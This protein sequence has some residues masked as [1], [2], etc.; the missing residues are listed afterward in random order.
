[1]T[2]RRV[3][4]HYR[5][6]TRKHVQHIY[7]GI[8]GF[9]NDIEDSKYATC[10]GEITLGGMERLTSIFQKLQPILSYPVERRVFYDLGSGV[11][12]NVIMIAS[13]I[14]AIKSKGIELVKERHEKAMKAY[15]TLNKKVQSRVEL[16][17]GSFFDHSIHN[18]AW[19]FISNLCFSQEINKKL[20]EKLEK[21]VQSNTLIACSVELVLNDTFEL[22][23]K[24]IIPMTWEKKSI[25]V[26]YRKK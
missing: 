2:T 19:M 13:L 14:Q 11:G 16:I 17:Y 7:K 25:V 26:I 18:S 21:D 20:E 8:D 22:L 6:G 3:K 9:G 12:K 10:Y 23:G 5:T 1:M 15:H 24:F 4:H